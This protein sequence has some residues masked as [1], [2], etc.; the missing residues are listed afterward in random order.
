MSASRVVR[1]AA[2]AVALVLGGAGMT[3]SAFAT[4]NDGR[5]PSQQ[6]QAKS[7]PKGCMWNGVSSN[8]GDVVSKTVHHADG[9]S[10][11]HDYTCT[12]GTWVQS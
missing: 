2:F 7:K 9:S 1:S 8:N 4:R 5:S 10:E 6:A 11:V 3:G 12:N